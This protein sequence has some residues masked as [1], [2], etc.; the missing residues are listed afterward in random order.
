M[1]KKSLLITFICLNILTIS[2]AKSY[3]YK[4][5]NVVLNITK[6]GNVIVTQERAYAFSGQFSWAYL[7]LNKKGSKDIDFIEIVDL[8]KNIRLAYTLE[9]DNAHVKALWRYAAKDETKK[10]KIKYIIYK[11]IQRYEDVAQFYWKIIEEKHEFIKS[12]NITILLPES[13]SNLFKIFVH[14]YA[15]PGNIA[16]SEDNSSAS[17][18]MQNVPKDTFVELRLLTAP[19]IFSEVQKINECKYE[20]I[21]N[22]EKTIVF[23]S[24]LGGICTFF[25]G[26]GFIILL[27]AIHLALFLY[28]YMK[29]GREPKIEYAGIYE[30][31]FPHDIPP[32]A[33]AVVVCSDKKID[34]ALLYRGILATIYDLARRGYI[35]VK[36]EENKIIFWIKNIQKFIL[37]EKG[38]KELDGKTHS[39]LDFEYDVLSF[40][41]KENKNANEITSEEVVEWL[42]ISSKQ[43]K[44]IWNKAKSWFE[45][46]Y[47]KIYDET[48]IKQRKLLKILQIIC[49][50]PIVYLLL[51][52]YYTVNYINIIYMY[53]TLSFNIALIFSSRAILKRTP[54]SALEVKKWEAFEKYITDFSE[55]KKA[56]VILIHI[57]DRY[58][59]YAV[60][61]GVAKN[62][63][64][65]I[66][67]LCLRENIKIPALAWYSASKKSPSKI[68]TPSDISNFIGNFSDIV[69]ALSASSAVGGG[70][71]GGGGGG[72][73]GGGSSGA[74]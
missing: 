14:S 62:L 23:N 70:F 20:R 13:S 26:I 50:C 16:F 6:E 68:M 1:F 46:K 57:W 61:L 36:E 54:E 52:N 45:K 11:V 28:F 43:L 22:E 40:L 2:Y 34:N 55:M 53:I 19:E 18:N 7:D 21:L 27:S 64:K 67:K 37:T 3:N 59:I 8:D 51:T 69:N 15:Q 24:L 66:E 35:I 63:L 10:F 31:E 72:G 39:L 30:R 49:V 33:L 41:F 29:Y 60:V 74:G 65:N 5:I 58:L 12:L 73:G 25:K 38:K 4:Y 9:E 71:S 44:K 56:P 32:L 48:S 17:I 42:K 47:F